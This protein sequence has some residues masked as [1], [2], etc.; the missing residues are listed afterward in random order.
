MNESD[1]SLKELL[2]R[3][4]LTASFQNFLAAVS[5]TYPELGT[6]QQYE[7]ILIGYEAANVLLKTSG[8]EYFL[9]I[10]ESGRDTENI[11][12]L[13]QVHIRAKEIG[14]PVPQLVAGKEGFLS[15]FP[16][17]V[18][19][20]Y[21]I[22]EK[23]VG[24]TFEHTEPSLEDMRQVCQYLALLNTLSFPVKEEYDSWGNKNIVREFDELQGFYQVK[25]EV[26]SIVEEVRLLPLGSFSKGVIHGDVQTKHVLKNL[27]GDYC[28]LDFGCISLDA[29]IIELSIFLAWFCLSEKN[30]D[31]YSD[32]FKEMLSIYSRLH[33]LS[34]EEMAAI[35]L[36]I[37]ATY[38]SYYLKTSQLIEEGDNSSETKEWNSSAYRL[39]KLS[40]SLK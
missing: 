35:P 1:T 9:K 29:K 4:A 13:V 30:W 32:I 18:E 17:E 22:T 26:R 15:V 16:D 11:D 14:V 31:S 8:G 12:A 34:Q 33:P 2:K 37:R 5:N 28:L 39:L 21:F 38:A 24:V 19:V 27:A 6:I 20:P 25:E 23:F 10:F 3:T 7:P 40:E 36:L